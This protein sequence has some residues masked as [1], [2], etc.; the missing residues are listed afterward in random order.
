MVKRDPVTGK[1]KFLG[2]IIRRRRIADI[3]LIL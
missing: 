1:K 2:P 3:I